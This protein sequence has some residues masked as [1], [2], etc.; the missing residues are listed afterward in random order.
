M[1]PIEKYKQQKQVRERVASVQDRTVAN[2]EIIKSWIEDGMDGDE[3]VSRIEASRTSL[4]EQLESCPDAV[5]NLYEEDQRAVPMANIEETRRLVEKVHGD[6]RI[7][8]DPIPPPPQCNKK[9]GEREEPDMVKLF[10][11]LHGNTDAKEILSVIR[12]RSEDGCINYETYRW[13]YVCIFLGNERISLLGFRK[14]VY[15]GEMKEGAHCAK[16]Y[17]ACE[18]KITE[19]DLHVTGRVR[20]ACGPSFK[21]RKIGVVSKKHRK[22]EPVVEA[23]KQL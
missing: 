9:G 21:L 4:L 14:P 23:E 19:E 18:G 8:A 13:K 17:F 15:K 10:A 12:R 3:V 7:M 16:I 6:L 22:T 2:Q 11:P 20:E 5:N 1:T